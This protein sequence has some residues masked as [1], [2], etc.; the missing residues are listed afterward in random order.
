E[1]AQMVRQCSGEKENAL[2]ERGLGKCFSIT[3]IF[4]LLLCQIDQKGLIFNVFEAK[5][6]QKGQK[7]RIFCAKFM[8]GKFYDKKIS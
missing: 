2:T 3:S 5:K 4:L 7:N 1:M 6:G 8:K